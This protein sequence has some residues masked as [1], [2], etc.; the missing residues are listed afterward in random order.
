[1][2]DR[3][4]RRSP[5]AE[6]GGAVPDHDVSG[7]RQTLKRIPFIDR[8]LRALRRADDIEALQLQLQHHRQLVQAPQASAPPT[9]DS[10]WTGRIMDESA[11]PFLAWR[12]P[13]HYYSPVPTMK[14]IEAQQD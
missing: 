14:E 5:G 7:W 4:P 13:G 8:E 3:Q 9:G 6:S 2:S 1:M 10:I 12:P 11:I